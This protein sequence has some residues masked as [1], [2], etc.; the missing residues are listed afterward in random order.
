[1]RIFSIPNLS[2]VAM[3]YKEFDLA[4]HVRVVLRAN[5]YGHQAKSNLMIIGSFA[6]QARIR[7]RQRDGKR[8]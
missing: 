1:M 5:C 8:G 2:F 6:T 3:E 7:G 4:G